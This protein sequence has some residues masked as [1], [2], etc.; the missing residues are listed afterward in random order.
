MNTKR[1]MQCSLFLAALGWAASAAFADAVGDYKVIL[2][3]NPF[4]LKPPPAPLPP[5][6]TP[7]PVETPTNYKLSGIT[8]L[9]NPPRAM[10]VN[11]P[12]GK[13]TPEYISLSEGQLQGSLEV[14][15]NGINVKAGTVRVKISGEERTLSFEKDGLKAPS[16]PPVMTAPGVPVPFGQPNPV[17]S[18]PGGSVAYPPNVPANIPV[19]STGYGRP[20]PATAQPAGTQAIP[21]P[22]ISPGTPNRPLRGSIPLTSSGNQTEPPPAPKIDPVEQAVRMELDR[23]INRPRVVAGELPPLPPTDLTGR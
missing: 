14:L 15:P 2:D 4:G 11:Q 3:R 22:Q 8:A 10:F 18:T 6:P 17:P 20:Q 23:T 7:P 9:F 16:G 5:P 19:P 1:A 21:A 13:P 12:P